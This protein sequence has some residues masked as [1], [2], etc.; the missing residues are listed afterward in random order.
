MAICC[1]GAT[2]G[3][4][5]NNIANANLPDLDSIYN[6]P[7]RRT[8][9]AYRTPSVS[10]AKYTPESPQG[11][12][13][14]IHITSR[15]DDAHL[16]NTVRQFAKQQRGHAHGAAGF[17]QDLEPR[18][19][20]LHRRADFIVGD[21]QDLLDQIANDG[22]SQRAG[23]RSAQAIGDGLG[24]RDGVALAG[25]EREKCVVAVGRLDAEQADRR[26]HI[27]SDSGAARSEEH[28]SELQSLR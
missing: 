14:E 10:E 3:K 8:N 17:H 5:S 26:A 19:Q 23:L 25:L 11:Q 13:I 16:T 2:A 21:Q 20:E 15:Q 1:A 7:S 12:L 4:I 18:E 9:P 22:E 28:T 6:P 27:F 24:Q